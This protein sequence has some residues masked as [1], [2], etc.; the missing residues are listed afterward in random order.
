[1]R[2]TQDDPGYPKRLA[3]LGDMRAP[4]ELS[5][6][7]GEPE[8]VVAIVGSR[9]PEPHARAFVRGLARALARAGVTIVSGGA[10]GIDRAAHDG[11]LDGGGATW[12]VSPSGR[13]APYP[14]G[15]ADFFATIATS[16]P[17]AMLWPFEDDTPFHAERARARNRI[18][19]ALA[20]AVVV[21]QARLPSGS[22]NAARWA[23]SLGKPLW[24]VPAAPWMGGHVGSM[25]ELRDGK[26]RALWDV[27]E[28]FASLGLP[29]PARRDLSEETVE[30]P[31]PGKA[32][33]LE[34]AQEPLFRPLGGR[35][36]LNEIA[37]LSCLSMCPAHVDAIVDRTA[38][39]VGAVRS[40]LLTLTMKNV[41]VEGPDGFFRR[42][43]EG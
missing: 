24:I 20:D 17:S 32:T 18:L 43:M 23:R 39:R 41:V 9:H 11:A 29:P 7:L 3:I 4:L 10:T 12:V 37:V 16:P 15:H 34:E 14:P 31:R 30:L 21:V 28:L 19:V 5:A 27:H 42:Q 1:V 8:R 6:P 22:L 40:A 13:R 38:L 35:L 26:A 2:L 25:R 36:D 33:P